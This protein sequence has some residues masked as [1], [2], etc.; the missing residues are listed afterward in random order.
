M[1]ANNK[2]FVVTGGGNGIGREVVLNLLNKGAK[3]AAID[4]NENTLNET[5]ELAGDMSGQLS[6]HKVDITDRAAVEDLPGQVK[7]K[8]GDI[9]G[10]INVAGIIQPFVKIKALEFSAMERVMNVNFWGTMNMVKTFLPLL[11]ERPE[12]HIVNVSS[13]GGF[14]PFP[15][16]SI[17]G[18]SKAAIKIMTEGLAAE[19]SDTNV[20]VTVIFPGAVGTNIAKNS[21]L[22]NIGDPDDAQGMKG[23]EP[24]EAAAIIVKGMEKNKARVYAGKDSKMMN[25][26]YKLNPKFAVNFITKQMRPMLEVAEK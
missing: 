2:V 9:D 23:L 13:M 15:G 7:E 25:I 21:G 12:A 20:G 6:I 3:V 22:D 26:M 1:K 24:S 17:Y 14:F 10:L 11:L 16:Q 5:V 19:L 4:I 8:H 18:A